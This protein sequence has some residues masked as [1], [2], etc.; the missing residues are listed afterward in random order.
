MIVC[1]NKQAKSLS[2]NTE[3]RVAVVIV[4]G[5]YCALADHYLQKNSYSW[6]VIFSDVLMSRPIKTPDKIT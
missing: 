6:A 1:S 4:S 5:L 3:K 2:D